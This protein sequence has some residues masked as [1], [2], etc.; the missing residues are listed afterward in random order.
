M[1]N[2]EAASLDRPQDKQ[3]AAR[4]NGHEEGTRGGAHHII[5]ASKQ[6]YRIFAQADGGMRS[7]TAFLVSGRRIVATNS[8]VVSNGTA[9][10][11]GYVSEEGRTEWVK[12]E[13]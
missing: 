6:V 12:L 9:F 11:L 4:G 2:S 13:I 10:A 5:S 7:G 3:P 8:H 1:H